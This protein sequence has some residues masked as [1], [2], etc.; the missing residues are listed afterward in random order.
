MKMLDI[1]SL[2]QGVMEL[3]ATL[4]TPDDGSQSNLTPMLWSEP[5]EG[6][7]SI[8]RSLFRGMRTEVVS[9]A[10]HEPFDFGGFPVPSPEHRI[11]KYLPPEWAVFDPEEP[12]CIFLDDAPL[13]S[14]QTY[15]AVMKLALERTIG[16]KYRIGPLVKIILAGNPNEGHELIDPLANRLVHIAYKMSVDQFSESLKGDY[17]QLPPIP[18]INPEIHMQIRQLYRLKFAAFLDRFPQHVS[19]KRNNS[20]PYPNSFATKRS[21][22]MATRLAATAEM[23]GIAPTVDGKENKQADEVFLRLM[24]GAIG[25]E[26]AVPLVRFL[27]MS[28]KIG[29]PREILSGETTVDYS[30][31]TDDLIYAFF[32]GL[33][34]ELARLEANSPKEFVQGSMLFC[35]QIQRLGNRIDLVYA[36][37]RALIR[38]GWY[39]RVSVTAKE[40]EAFDEWYRVTMSVFRPDGEF[41]QFGSLIEKEASLGVN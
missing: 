29:D 37:I 30:K 9:A 7:T 20:D 41:A 31:F 23:L 22:E 1:N 38:S 26:V 15:A 25:S 2:P 34:F 14:M 6:K 39:Q 17:A 21:L 13:A 36:P 8:I 18:F 10:L 27:C 3:F 11:V 33:G 4:A 16:T 35:E 32:C 28:N 24:Q 19:S 5:G 40:L 12:G